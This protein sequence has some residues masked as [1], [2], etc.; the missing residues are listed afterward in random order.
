[1]A[2]VREKL[3]KDTLKV[4][5]TP[6]ELISTIDRAEIQTQIDH[7]ELEK[8]QIQLEIDE[9]NADIAKLDA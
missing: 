5:N 6:T 8:A 7:K 3:D 4:T 1:M 2:E 9:L